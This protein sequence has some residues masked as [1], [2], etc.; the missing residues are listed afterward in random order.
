MILNMDELF[1]QVFTNK[2]LLREIYKWIV[3]H[4]TMIK[5]GRLDMVRIVDRLHIE[6]PQDA[7]NL[8]ILTNNFEMVELLYSKGYKGNSNSLMHAILQKNIDIVKFLVEKNYCTRKLFLSVVVNYDC[9]IEICQLICDALEKFKDIDYTSIFYHTVIRD[10][11]EYLQLFLDKGFDCDFD[12]ITEV[13]TKYGKLHLL[14]KLISFYSKDYEQLFSI[15]VDNNNFHVI[16]WL[17]EN[18]YVEKTE[19]LLGLLKQFADSI[20]NWILDE[21]IR[22]TI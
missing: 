19:S 17:I 11:V 5:R 8:A 16:K 10:K 12:N 1:F 2:D 22:M 20:Q 4:S 6:P 15:A 13:A 3:P 21:T 14:V 9:G 7:L 18:E